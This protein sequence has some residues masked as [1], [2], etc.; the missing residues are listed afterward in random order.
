MSYLIKSATGDWV[1]GEAG[2]DGERR[3]SLKGYTEREG[4][5]DRLRLKHNKILLRS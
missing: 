4:V 2:I 1:G 3:A 5:G